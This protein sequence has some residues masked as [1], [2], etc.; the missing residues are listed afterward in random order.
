MVTTLAP[1]PLV[2]SL[3]EDSQSTFGYGYGYGN[4]DGNGNG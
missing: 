4:G 2:A 3:G 1:P